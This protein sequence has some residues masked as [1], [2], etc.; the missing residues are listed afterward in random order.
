MI[1][2]SMPL[3]HFINL[4]EKLAGMTG[5]ANPAGDEFREYYDLE[6]IHIDSYKTCIRNDLPDLVFETKEAKQK[7]LIARIKQLHEKGQPVLIGTG[8]VQ[9]SED[10]YQALKAVGIACNVLNAK[11]DEQEAEIIKNAG[12]FGAVTVSTNMAGRGVDIK[13]GGFDEADYAK[14][15]ELGGLFVI[16]TNRNESRRIDNQLRGRAGRQGDPGMSQ[17]YISL[18]DDMMLKYEVKNFLPNKGYTSDESGLI[19]DEKIT[20][21]VAWLQRRVESYNES[22]RIQL[23]KYTHVLELQRK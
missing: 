13:L 3:Q 6:I 23:L 2:N 16:G 18:E 14:V 7:A 22:A 17:Y 19:T 12:A 15:A 20:D 1:L 5:T 4:Y 11:N 10:L 8:S 21:A 9:E